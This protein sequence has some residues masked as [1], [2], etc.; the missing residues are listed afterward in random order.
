MLF[1]VLRDGG[2]ACPL[3]ASGPSLALQPGRKGLEPCP[4]TSQ[5]IM[6]F[7]APPDGSEACPLVL[8]GVGLALSPG[9]DGFEPGSKKSRIIMLNARASSAASSRHSGGRER[10]AW[11][12]KSIE[13]CHHTAPRRP[14]AAVRRGFTPRGQHDNPRI[15]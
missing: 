6:L 1:P 10:L 2:Q 14:T 12:P 8:C 5:I 15:L 3:G 13:P 4:S 9:R 7:L 11:L